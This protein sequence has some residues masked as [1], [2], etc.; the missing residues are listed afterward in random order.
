MEPID[1]DD[2]IEILKMVEESNFDEL[3][4]EIGGLKLVVKKRGGKTVAVQEPE[5]RREEPAKLA[6][7]EKTVPSVSDQGAETRISSDH[8]KEIISKGKA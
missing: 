5:I 6:V 4:L 8:E 3:H 7:I 2:V 1:Q